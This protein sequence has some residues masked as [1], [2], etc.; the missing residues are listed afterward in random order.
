M[1]LFEETYRCIEVDPQKF[2]YKQ[3][4]FTTSN[5]DAGVTHKNF[6]AKKIAPP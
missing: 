5:G 6:G 2:D 1:T 3:P 4:C